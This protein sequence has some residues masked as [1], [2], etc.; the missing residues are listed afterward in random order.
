VRCATSC[1]RPSNERQSA[2]RDHALRL[3]DM[4]TAA[5]AARDYAAGM[6]EPRDLCADRRSR[7]AI[8]HNLF[9]LGEAAKAIPAD[10]RALAPQIEWRGIAGL[11]DVLAHEYF[12]IDDEV[13]WDIV[14]NR[15]P[16]LVAQLEQMVHV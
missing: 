12:G 15:L 13:V 1:A 4:L 14:K 16:D 8:L 11:R 2:L 10:V 7:D 6:S 9:V 5:I 3:R